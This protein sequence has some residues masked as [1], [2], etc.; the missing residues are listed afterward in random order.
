MHAE[1]GS[2]HD[3]IGHS[4]TYR[5]AAGPRAGQK[6]FTLQAGSACAQFTGRQR[7]R[8]QAGLNFLSAAVR[9]Q[10]CR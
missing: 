2:L 3:L 8:G 10:D 4:I 7:V 1:G 9:H 5:V 6:L